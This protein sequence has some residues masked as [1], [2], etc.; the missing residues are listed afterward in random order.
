MRTLID[1]LRSRINPA[2][3]AQKGTESYERRIC[4][5]ALEK[6]LADIDRA[7][8]TTAVLRSLLAEWLLFASDVVPSCA[9]GFD[10]LESL[11][12]RTERL[13]C[14]N[15]KITCA[16]QCGL[17]QRDAASSASGSSEG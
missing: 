12:A 15:V 13:M 17:A 8:K 10:Q 11:R 1:D 6:M 7:G 2:Y 16:A 4:V 3:A 14:T 5:E 9:A